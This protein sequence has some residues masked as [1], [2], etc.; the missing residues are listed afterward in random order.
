M[1]YEDTYIYARLLLTTV[2]IIP[3]NALLLIHY[4]LIPFP[5]HLLPPLPFFHANITIS[6]LGFP[7][8]SPFNFLIH[9]LPSPRVHLYTIIIII[10]I[11]Y[12]ARHLHKFQTL[13]IAPSTRYTAFFDPVR[14]PRVTILYRHGVWE[15]VKD[16]WWSVWE[17]GVGIGGWEVLVCSQ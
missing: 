7:P 3:I 8:R 16:W 5:S 13:V 6:N 15:F 2:S 12:P 10:T 17:A 9:K 1:H 4:Q 14:I 11:T